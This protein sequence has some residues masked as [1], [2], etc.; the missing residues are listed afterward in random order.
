MA[1]VDIKIHTNLFNIIY[2]TSIIPTN[3]LISMFITTPKKQTAKSHTEYSTINLMSH[4]LKVFIKIIHGRSCQICEDNNDLIQFGFRR[5]IGMREALH[6][7]Q[8]FA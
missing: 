5:S 3:W 4:I 8:F 6:T 7:M 1:E 2:D